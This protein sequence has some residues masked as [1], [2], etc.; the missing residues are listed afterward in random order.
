MLRLKDFIL[1]NCLAL[2]V[3]SSCA[4][5]TNTDFVY[6]G[7]GIKFVMQM[8]RIDYVF[9]FRKDGTFCKN[10]DEPDWQTLVDGRYRMTKKHIIMEYLKKA[11]KNDTIFLNNNRISSDNYGTKLVRLKVPNE[12]PEG[13]YRFSSASSS[14]GMGTGVAYVGTQREKGLRFYNDGR[15]NESVSNT[16]VVSGGNVAGGTSGDNEAMGT[17]TIENGLLT[18]NYDDGRVE[19]NSFFYESSKAREPMVVI[20]GDI[21]FDGEEEEVDTPISQKTTNGE[22]SAKQ[23]STTGRNIEALDLLEK[24]KKRHGGI[25]I[26]AIKTIKSQIVTSGVK[27][28]VLMDLE[29]S[30]LRIEFLE[31]SFSYVEQLDGNSG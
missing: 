25:T 2:L 4:R 1:L 27:F 18:L 24:T 13:Y 22:K 12:V 14:G 29:K 31:P 8:E 10:L 19:K 21:Y 23:P 30:R 5:V 11:K 15:F 26:D 9:L 17:Y 28:K 6:A 3:F 16:V 7:V 20:N